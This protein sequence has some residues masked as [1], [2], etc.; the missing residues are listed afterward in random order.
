[1]GVVVQVPAAQGDLLHA[2]VPASTSLRASGAARP[3]CLPLP[4]LLLELGVDRLAVHI[5]VEAEHVLS[6]ETT[7]LRAL[8]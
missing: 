3:K 5:L 2:A 1:M 4:V 8:S 6:R 7:R